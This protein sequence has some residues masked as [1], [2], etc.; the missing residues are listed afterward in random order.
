MRVG[1]QW[2]WRNHQQWLRMQGSFPIYERKTNKPWRSTEFRQKLQS[3]SALLV[4]FLY[5]HSEGKGNC[6]VISKLDDVI[7]IWRNTRIFRHG[8]PTERFVIEDHWKVWVEF[9]LGENEANVQ[10]LKSFYWLGAKP[11]CEVGGR[12]T[13]SMTVNP[14]VLKTVKHLL[15]WIQKMGVFKCLERWQTVW[16][17]ST[18]LG[19]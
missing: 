1:C 12:T 16:S 3:C 10:V 17:I 15:W 4:D 11:W 19:W 14:T 9:P 18:P 7:G 2:R 5:S 13:N 6:L 8:N